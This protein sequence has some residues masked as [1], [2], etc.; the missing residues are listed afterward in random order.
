MC[1][2]KMGF[3]GS[4]GEKGQFFIQHIPCCNVH[5]LACT[6]AV[7]ELAFLISMVL[8]VCSFTEIPSACMNTSSP[9]QY[10][11][12]LIAFPP[13]GS[14][15]NATRLSTFTSAAC[16]LKSWQ[17]KQAVLTKNHLLLHTINARP[18]QTLSFLKGLNGKHRAKGQPPRRPCTRIYFEYL[19]ITEGDGRRASQ[20]LSPHACV[21]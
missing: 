21:K 13:L 18:S 6:A 15:N 17:S 19:K 7:W 16:R 9:Q 14:R 20:H 8:F 10:P 3:H 12:M 11:L 1:N 4:R 2:H 5:V